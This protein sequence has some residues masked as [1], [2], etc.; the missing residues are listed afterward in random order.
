MPV[1]LTFREEGA[2]QPGEQGF[3]GAAFRGAVL[4]A[5]ISSQAPFHGAQQGFLRAAA[6]LCKH[7]HLGR[8]L[9]QGSGTPHSWPGPPDLLDKRSF[10]RVG[11]PR[12]LGL[13]RV[14]HPAFRRRQPAPAAPVMVVRTGTEGMPFSSPENQH[15]PGPGRREQRR[16]AERN[17]RCQRRSNPAASLASPPSSGSF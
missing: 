8:W 10:G 5:A 16:Q 11:A 6:R 7:A 3:L 12:N 14:H 4:E 15:Q 17:G 9:A 1:A 13:W 2:W